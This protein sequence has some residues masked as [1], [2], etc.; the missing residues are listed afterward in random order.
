MTETLPE[1]KAFARYA[2]AFDKAILGDFDG[3][4]AEWAEASRSDSLRNFAD[5]FTNKMQS[6]LNFLK[7]EPGSKQWFT[8]KMANLARRNPESG[9]PVD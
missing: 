2:L 7:L 4:D 5:F 1:K 6:I 3:A 9:T 8:N